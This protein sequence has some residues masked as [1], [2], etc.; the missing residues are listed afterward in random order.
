MTSDDPEIIRKTANETVPSKFSGLTRP[1]AEAIAE[2]YRRINK[3]LDSLNES[4]S[5]D[6][7]DQAKYSISRGWEVEESTLRLLKTTRYDL[8]MEIK[9]DKIRE[10]PEKYY[11]EARKKVRKDIAREDR[12]AFLRP[13]KRALDWLLRRR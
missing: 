3:S 7:R 12:E 9:L 13:F 8:E 6:L 10:D 5:E 4:L 1:Q 2:S 11:A